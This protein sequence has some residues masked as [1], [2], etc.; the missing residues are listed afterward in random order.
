MIAVQIICLLVLGLF[1][2]VIL[3]V[4]I[5]FIYLTVSAGF[6]HS[7]PAVPSHGKVKDAIISEA[8]A[9]LQNS[10][11]KTVMDLGSGWGTLL[12][13]LA[14]K[15]PNHKFVGIERGYLPFNVSVWR[16]RKLKNLTFLRQDFF[17]TD[18]AQA[19]L[20]FVFLLNST[21]AQLTAKIKTEMK[22]DSL[23]IANRFPMKDEK[24][25]KEVSLG[26]KYYTYF[27]YKN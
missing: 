1:C 22:P 14:K 8:A 4:S 23:V 10:T 21:M 20:I 13:P 11:N 25:Y 16:A 5:A 26:S 12:L 15:F 3:G 17:K 9:I 2:L 24:P 7:S 27:V 19:D 6:M 18:I